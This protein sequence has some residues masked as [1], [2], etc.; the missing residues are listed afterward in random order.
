VIV[1]PPPAGLVELGAQIQGAV[2]I[3]KSIQELS[4][5]ATEA[6]G[7]GQRS[8]EDLQD[9]SVRL[10]VAFDGISDV[11]AR[12][13]RLEQAVYGQRSDVPGPQPAQQ[14]PRMASLAPRRP[15]SRLAPD[16]QLP[17]PPPRDPS[18]AAMAGITEADQQKWFDEAKALAPQVPPAL[19]ARVTDDYVDECMARN[20][21][22]GSHA[23]RSIADRALK[24]MGAPAPEATISAEDLSQDIVTGGGEVDDPEDEA[25][26][27]V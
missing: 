19:L 15:T 21:E 5:A 10:A 23:A 18:L 12:V 3:I 24:L 7:G 4:G 17:P 25:P 13:V 2:R 27:E 11:L 22:G 1:A 14:A 20:G 6:L 9:L 8:D 26:A 16:V